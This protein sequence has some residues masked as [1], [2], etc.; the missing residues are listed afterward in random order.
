MLAASIVG[1]W[2]AI[3]QVKWTTQDEGPTM[4]VVKKGEFLYQITERGDIESTSNVEIR[5]EVRARGTS[6]AKILWI[7]K[8]GSN[9]KPKDELIKFDK[10]AFESELTKQQ[11]ECNR[12]AAALIKAKNECGNAT[13]ALAKYTKGTFLVEKMTIDIK[14]F[15]AEEEER[16]AQQ[17]VKYTEELERKGYVT[18]LRLQKDKFTLEKA[19]LNFKLATLEMTVLK[20]FTYPKMTSKLN[21]DIKTAEATSKSAKAKRDLDKKELERVQEQIEKCVVKAKKAGQVVYANETRW[22]DDIIIEAGAQIRQEQVVIRLPD[23]KRMQV[24]ANINEAEVTAVKAGQ[25]VQI[26]LKAMP[27]VILE[28]IVEKV[29]EYPATS[30]WWGSG[31]KQYETLIK[32]VDSEVLLKPG[33]TAEVNIEIERIANCIKVPVQAIFEHGEKFYCVKH[34]P[35]NPDGWIAHEIEVGSSNEKFV[36]ITSGLKEGEEIVH[37]AFAYRK[38]VELPKLP[39]DFNKSKNK[40]KSDSKKAKTKTQKQHTKLSKKSRHGGGGQS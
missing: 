18:D 10:S 24:K 35:K 33:L 32:I 23:P 4:H 40:R 2:Y 28:G 37:G 21:S 15:A 26:T 6:G 7:I 38:K 14:K 9:V 29:S 20:D 22:G 39:S 1:A 25:Q 17:K 12:S 16:Q 31:S 36:V 30:R 27:D 34:D 13:G 5:C 19:K 3:R 11:I 8:E